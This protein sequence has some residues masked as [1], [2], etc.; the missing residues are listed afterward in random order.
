MLHGGNHTCGDHPFTY[1]ASH[2]DT[3]VGYKNLIWTHQTKGQI[4]TSLMSFACISWPKQVSSYWCPLVV[5]SL[6]LFN[7]EGLIHAVFSEQ[8]M[9]KY[10]C[11]LNCESFIWVLLWG[12]VNSNKCMHDGARAHPVCVP[13]NELIHCRRGNSGSSFPV[14]VIMTA[15]FIIALDRFCDCTWRNFQSFYKCSRKNNQS[16]RRN[17]LSWGP[18]QERKTQSYICCRR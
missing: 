6:Q 10:V 12:A 17:C 1:S 4:S 5:V 3:K 14:A 11:F 15:S 13:C 18:P 8:L 16:L 9:L 2:K 7:H